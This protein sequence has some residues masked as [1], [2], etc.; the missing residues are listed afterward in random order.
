[1]SVKHYGYDPTLAPADK[2]VVEVMFPSNYAYWKPLYEDRERYDAEKQ[3]IALTV[4]AQLDKRFPG[5]SDQV[6]AVDVATPMTYE[7]YTGNWQGSMEGWLI[8][9]KTM[10]LR[11]P[12]TL[13]GLQNFYMAGQW[14]EPGGGLPPAA[15][16]GRSVIK[17][18]CKQDKQQFVTRVP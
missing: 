13:P 6:E 9:T 10:M 12:K 3:Q 1:M 8:T 2:S 16:S 7:R 5:L 15:T 17:T 18:I 14:V 11:M 4:M